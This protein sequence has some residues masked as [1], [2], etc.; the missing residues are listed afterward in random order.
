MPY[1]KL[2]SRSA[3]EKNLINAMSLNCTSTLFTKFWLSGNGNEIDR[4]CGRV[5]TWNIGGSHP[6]SGLDSFTLLAVSSL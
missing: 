5:S 2:I 3:V 1:V 4:V 6:N